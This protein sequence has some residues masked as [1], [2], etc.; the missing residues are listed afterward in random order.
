M[1]GKPDLPIGPRTWL[2][3]AMFASFA[4]VWGVLASSG[5]LQEL[6][7]VMTGLRLDG[8]VQA[9]RQA[10]VTNAVPGVLVSMHFAPGEAVEE[11]QLLFQLSSEAHRHR[12]E[13]SAAIVKRK[14]VELEI[15]RRNKDRV[16]RL[17]ERGTATETAAQDAEDRFALA[18]VALAE[19]QA[20]LG[21]NET[22]LNAT[23][24][25]APISGYIGAPHF[26]IGAYLET[27][28]GQT[29]AEII[30]V[31]PILVGY[32]QPF[33]LLLNMH[34]ASPVRLRTLFDRIV[35]TATLPSGEILPQTGRIKYVDSGLDA[36]G[37]LEVWAEFANPDSILV[38]GLKVGLGLR[39]DK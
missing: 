15:A 12:V 8:T 7:E 28:S 6:R 13:A 10:F 35:V 19:A 20:N 9:G 4:C 32:K 27:E 37:Y 22:G 5:D 33:D 3:R 25:T 21:L 2:A 16:S 31:D 17:F 26:P 39:V 30:Q 1:V 29:L 18:E 38:P 36:G 14:R 11:G 34:E 24:I 23:Q